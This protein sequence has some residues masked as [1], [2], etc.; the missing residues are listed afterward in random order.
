MFFF[1]HCILAMVNLGHALPKNTSMPVNWL[2][3][4]RTTKCVCVRE[5]K[6]TS[7]CEHT[8]PSIYLP[9]NKQHH[10]SLF[11]KDMGMI[12]LEVVQYPSFLFLLFRQIFSG[13]LVSLLVRLLFNTRLLFWCQPTRSASSFCFFTNKVLSRD[14]SI[15]STRCTISTR[16][17]F[18]PSFFS[19]I[20]PM[21]R[22]DNYFEDFVNRTKKKKKRSDNTQAL[23]YRSKRGAEK[24]HVL[25]N[26]ARRE[27]PE[28]MSVMTNAPVLCFCSV[29][30]LRSTTKIQ[31]FP[32]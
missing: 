9:H 11:H 16:V 18:S 30:S 19:T 12:C 26:Q 28:K 21:D 27:L 23:R 6:S 3:G 31:T 4:K 25:C 22:K 32:G 13:Q 24:R 14:R 29:V 7:N 5:R 8:P 2:Q 10:T 20:S 1:R 15:Q 17:S